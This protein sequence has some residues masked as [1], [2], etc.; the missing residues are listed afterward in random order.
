L[1]A[2]PKHILRSIKKGWL[3]RIL[4]SI[5]VARRVLFANARRIVIAKPSFERC[6]CLHIGA[7]STPTMGQA[8]ITMP[9]VLCEYDAI[10][11]AASVATLAGARTTFSPSSCTEYGSKETRATKHCCARITAFAFAPL[12]SK[13]SKND[14]KYHVDTFPIEG[15]CQLQEFHIYRATT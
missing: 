6:Q 5:R 13:A 3:D 4:S 10:E 15:R 9:P 14:E 1:N 2:Y 11:A 8:A 12:V 7:F